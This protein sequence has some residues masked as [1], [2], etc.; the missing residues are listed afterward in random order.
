[1]K[2]LNNKISIEFK[3]FIQRNKLYENENDDISIKPGKIEIQTKDDLMFAVHYLLSELGKDMLID[4][5][6]TF[7]DIYKEGKKS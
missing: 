2:T 7:E 3:N 5:L 6:L 4:N 1:M